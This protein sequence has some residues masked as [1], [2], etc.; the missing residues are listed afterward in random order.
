[1]GEDRKEYS[2]VRPYFTL[3][4]DPEEKYKKQRVFSLYL[5]YAFCGVYIFNRVWDREVK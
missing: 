4:F 1:M 2:K 5:L 3:E